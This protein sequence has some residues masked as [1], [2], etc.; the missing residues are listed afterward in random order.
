MTHN[1]TY[2]N[3]NKKKNTY[4]NNRH[5]WFFAHHQASGAI[6]RDV[7]KIEAVA[8]LLADQVKGVLLVAGHFDGSLRQLCRRNNGTDI[9][10]KGA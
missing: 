6:G 5:E 8:V 1:N 2:A 9:N 7:F 10:L 4:W 3:K